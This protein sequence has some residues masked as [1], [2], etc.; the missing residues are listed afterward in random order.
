MEAAPIHGPNLRGREPP[1]PVR[2]A[3][4]ESIRAC[5]DGTGVAAF[6]IATAGWAVL[7][8]VLTLAS[9][10]VWRIRL[11]GF[12][13]VLCAAVFAMHL[14]ALFLASPAPERS[15]TMSGRGRVLARVGG[16]AAALGIFAVSS[17]VPL[18]L[19]LAGGFGLGL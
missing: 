10:G 6:A 11:D 15:E 16:G 8:G 4:P 9:A 12:G 17:V 14:V 2:L 5:R 19:A 13:S 3:T 1:K 18:A 7:V